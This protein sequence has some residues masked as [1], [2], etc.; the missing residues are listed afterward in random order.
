MSFFFGGSS[1][2]PSLL[3]GGGG[4]MGEPT[5]VV[6]GGE[7]ARWSI[8]PT[9]LG[10]LGLLAREGEKRSWSWTQTVSQR[11]RDKC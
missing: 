9:G 6:E 4:G 7:G 5:D 11:S 3:G 2:P 10:A 8:I 1:A